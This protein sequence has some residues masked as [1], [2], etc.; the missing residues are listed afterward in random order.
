MEKGF[1]IIDE[2]IE[3]AIVQSIVQE[4]EQQQFAESRS[5]LRNAEKKLRSVRDLVDSDYLINRA[6]RYLSGQAKLVRVILFNKTVES[7][8][9]V[10]WHQDKTVAV[11]H[12]FNCRGWGPWSIKDKVQHVQPP[13]DVLDQMVT[14]RI[15]LDPVDKNNGGLKIIPGSHKQ[16]IMTQEQITGHVAANEP[17]Y[18]MG[19]QGSALV[20][21]PHLLHAS[22]KAIIP[23]QRRVLH[24]EYSS[25]DLPDEIQ[26]A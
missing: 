21:R 22:S 25:F 11:S 1:D 14:F 12:Q 26:W 15:H 5:G 17:L 8:W 2:L 6:E 24:V 18:C 7:N 9:L 16:G 4:F 10:S 3:P 23:A 19:E 20:M 13:L